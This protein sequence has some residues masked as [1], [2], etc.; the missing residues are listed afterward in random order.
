MFLDNKK[1]FLAGATGLAGISILQYLLKNCPKIAVRASYA[2]MKPFIEDGR[3]E[4]FQ[5]DLKDQAFCRKVASGCDCAIMAAGST[6]GSFINNFQAWKQVNENVLMNTQMLEAFYFE[7][8]KRIIFIGTASV[9]QEFDGYIKEDALDMNKDPHLAFLGIGYVTRFIEQLCKFWHQKYGMEIVMARSSNIYGP[10]ARF[11]PE[12]ANFIPAIIRKAVDKMDPFEVW[13]S[14]DVVRD[15]VYCEDFAEAI[16]SL[17]NREKIEFD[18]FNIGSGI[19][20]TV[21]N[22]VAWALE[23][24][25]HKPAKVVYDANK[26]TTIKFRALDISRIKK[27]I[28]WSPRHSAWEGIRKTT[29]WWVENK[30]EWTK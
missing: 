27:V 3:I 28:G 17:L 9:Y 12:T 2:R 15:V 26:P 18:V 30:G 20:T 22:V 8:V 25:D 23:A 29:Q 7:Q 4:Y 21:G 1:V 24:A 6:G 16:V 19:K 10:Y 11:N 5:G 13:G 14:A